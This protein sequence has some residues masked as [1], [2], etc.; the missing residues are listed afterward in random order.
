MKLRTPAELQ[1]AIDRETGWRKRELTTLLFNVQGERAAKRPTALRAGITLLYA[2]WEGWIKRIAEYY[3]GFV[4]Q[5]GLRC[6]ELSEPFLA[7]ALKAHM[8]QLGESKKARV[9]VAFAT[10]VRDGL[11]QPARFGSAGTVQT[12]SNLSS[13]VLQDILIRVGVDHVPYMMYAPLIDERMLKR[14]NT[15]AHGEYLD[16]DLAEFEDLHSNIT[17]L[18][19][20]F[21]TE[22][23]NGAAQRA[24]RT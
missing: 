6:D 8:N 15:V 12:E 4:E 9:H 5:Q 16:V 18:L 3:I 10:F 20:D 24:Y 21:T 1:D 23:L 7:L 22:V 17:E 13:A 14:R 11:V 19:R 2:H